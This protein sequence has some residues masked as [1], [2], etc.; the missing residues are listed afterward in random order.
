MN[1]WLCPGAVLACLMVA[2]VPPVGAQRAPARA[3]DEVLTAARAYLTDYR[4]KLAFVIADEAGTQRIIRQVPGVPGMPSTRGTRAE[5]HFRF[6]AEAGAWMAIRNV[7]A[8]DGVAVERRADL[9]AELEKRGVAEVIRDYKAYNSRFNIGRIERNFNEP[10]LALGLLEA[11]RASSLT[12]TLRGRRVERGVALVT[13]AFKEAPNAAPF[14]VDLNRG[15]APVDGEFVI[16][17]A[18]GR[19]RRTRLRVSFDL[20]PAEAVL[21]TTYAHDPKVDLWVPETFRETYEDGVEQRAGSG[22]AGA[23]AVTGHQFE[24]IYCE[25]RYSNYRRFQ[26]TARIK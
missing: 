20:G 2:A 22:A 14:V 7:T 1:R 13:V 5:I 16:E 17:E 6:V 8:V 21:T 15:Q 26:A 25:S 9:R 3:L 4:E 10:T 23:A 11:E 24:S 19:I 12:F 18:T